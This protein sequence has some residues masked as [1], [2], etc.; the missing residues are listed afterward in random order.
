MGSP[1]IVFYHAHNK[2]AYEPYYSSFVEVH[3]GGKEGSFSL[4]SFSDA[5]AAFRRK[6]DIAEKQQQVEAVNEVLREYIMLVRGV[7]DKKKA[8]V[9]KLQHS[10]AVSVFLSS[11]GA[12]F[13]D[14]SAS[15]T[16]ARGYLMSLRL[17][18][19]K[20]AASVREWKKEFRTKY[21]MSSYLP[22]RSWFGNVTGEQDVMAQFETLLCLVQPG[23]QSTGASPE[24]QLMV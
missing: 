9:G 22:F 6:V 13:S 21:E 24:E 3:G 1:I 12:D 7:L 15:F 20:L 23:D 14:F 19:R 4:T 11:R 2:T 5:V 10:V 8:F 17:E 18:M 16:S